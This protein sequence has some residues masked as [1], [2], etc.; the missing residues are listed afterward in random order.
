MDSDGPVTLALG[1]DL[2]T[3]IIAMIM[4]QPSRRRPG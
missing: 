3:D 1:S 4:I 2:D